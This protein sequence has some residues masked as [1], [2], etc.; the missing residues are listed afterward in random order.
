M[1]CMGKGLRHTIT[2]V[3]I[4]TILLAAS[5]SQAAGPADTNWPSYNGTVNGQR[6]SPLDQI[7]T[8]NV[9]SLT[10]VC[11]LQVDD[12]GTFQ[13]GLIQIDGTLYVTNAHDTLAMDAR[14]C[15]QR[16]R[17]IYRSEQED[18]FQINRGVGFSNGRLF[19]GTPDGRLL[20]IDASSG[21]TIWKQQIGDPAQ[22]EFLSSVPA[23]WQGLL[24][25]GTAGSDWGI[26]G[27]IMA[28]EQ[29][30]GREVWRFYTIPRGKETGADTWT[31]EETARY[32][33][34]GSWTTYTLDMASGEVF[35]PVGNPAPDFVPSHRPGANLFTN[36]MVVLDART[37]AL[38]W[39][40]QLLPNDG[41]D[42][43]LAAAPMLYW[44][45]KGQPMVALGSKDGHLYGINRETRERVFMTPVTTIK[46]PEKAPTA[47][48]VY[49]CPGPVGGVE[50]NGPAYDQLTK[51]IVVG[52]VDWCAVLKSDEVEFQPGKFF[53]AGSWEWDEAK[54][55]WI[56][57]VDPDTGALRW[58]YHAGAPVVA[59]ITPTAGGVTFSGDMEGNFLAFESTTGK[60]L[61]K[62]ATGG[63]LAG[64]VITYALGGTQ[65]VAITSGNVS[66]LSF[67]ESGK[68]TVIIYALA[69]RERSAAASAQPAS[70]A[71]TVP[72]AVTAAVASPD[73]GRG[74]DLFVKNCAACHGRNGEGGSGPALKGVGTRLDFTATVNW[75]ENPSAK[76]PRLYPSTLD[77]QAVVD[78]AVY[79]QG[80]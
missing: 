49:S 45:S 15:T 33:G 35:V 29:E 43:D 27:R 69:E 7:T 16:W 21:K 10:E 62:K 26:R 79:V 6:Y 66:R 77:A 78:V 1:T 53:L 31:E 14:N 73:A 38:K 12:S 18:V 54:S 72:T 20:A 60:V 59:A 51:Q 61:L 75:I 9:A 17:N 3:V 30:T 52:A 67:G 58:Q 65:Y 39:W 70:T 74:K 23:I 32:G 24:I 40:H 22:G 4:P 5:V 42:L 44:T 56:S 28:Y 64:G 71:T 50:W 48:G 34:G 55:G 25:A 57:A 41:L 8:K 36:S 47:R 76:M 68:P 11:R 63:A 19:R 80:F 37:G 2:A 46:Q 13:A